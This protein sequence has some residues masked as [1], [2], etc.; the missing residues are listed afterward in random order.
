MIRR[1]SKFKCMISWKWCWLR[2]S[3]Q[4]KSSIL[5]VMLASVFTGRSGGRK[6]LCLGASRIGGSRAMNRDSSLACSVQHVVTTCSMD[7]SSIFLRDERVSNDVTSRAVIISRPKDKDMIESLIL[8]KPVRNLWYK[9]N[10]NG[11]KAAG[12]DVFESCQFSARLC[13]IIQELR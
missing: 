3:P 4:S 8:G 2:V 6:V 7:C 10:Y 11:N 13:G 12:N 9:P 5:I 1:A